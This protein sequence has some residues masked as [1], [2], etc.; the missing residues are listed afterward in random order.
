MSTSKKIS[1]NRVIIGKIAAAHGV[2][3]TMLIQ[4]LTDF[5]QRFL[6]MKELVLERPGKPSITL[7]VKSI[8]PYEGKNSFFFNAEGIETMDA[9]Q[10]L[11]G[12]L[13]TIAKDERVKLSQNEFWIDDLKG[14]TAFDFETQAKLGTLEEIMETGSNDVYLIRTDDG[15]LKPVPAISEAVRK[16]DIEAGKIFLTVPEG[17]WD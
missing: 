16:I 7:K 10:M 12:S 9:A 11:K 8:S 4:P 1:P 17:L 15:A 14:L 2:K 13:I 6:K 3:G 5:P